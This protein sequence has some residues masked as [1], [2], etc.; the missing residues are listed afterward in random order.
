M[1]CQILGKCQCKWHLISLSAPETPLGSYW[2]RE[3]FLFCTG[4]TVTTVLPS[5]VPP[6]HTGDFSAIHFLHSELLWLA[7]IK[8]PKISALGMVVFKHT[9]QFWSFGKCV[10]TLCLPEPGSTF[11]RGSIGGSWDELEV[12]ALFCMGFP[13]RSSEVPSFNIKS[14]ILWWRWWRGRWRRSRERT[15]WYS[16]NHKWYIV[17]YIAINSLALSDEKWFLT[18]VLLL[19]TPMILK[20]FHQGKNCGSFLKKHKFDK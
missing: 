5:L 7:V 20:E 8:S 12:S 6:R 2:F 19:Y 1:I 14:W 9:S 11:A 10:C 15:R 4:R 18:A 16:R 17:G 13:R 3:K